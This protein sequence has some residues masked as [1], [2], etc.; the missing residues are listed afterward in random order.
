M[1]YDLLCEHAI[2]IRY[3]KGV[4]NLKENWIAY[5]LSLQQLAI[6]S[7]FA[8]WLY[9]SRRCQIKSVVHNEMICHGTYLN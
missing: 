2:C 1:F 6:K 5:G 9:G 4:N 7:R 3:I 8:Q